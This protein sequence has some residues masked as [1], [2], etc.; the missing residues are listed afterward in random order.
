MPGIVVG[1][2]GSTHSHKALAWAAQEAAIRNAPLTVLTVH[3]AVV[4]YAGGPTTY[5]GDQ[6]ETA[7]AR[8]AALAETEKVLS[9]LSGGRPS[10]VTVTAV[11]GLPAQELVAASEGADLIVVGSRGSGGFARL[12]LGSVTAQV[13]EHAACPV[14]IVRG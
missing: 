5:P 13:A 4:G 8:D 12:L 1:V 7:Q 2:D 6:A 14:T 3:Q 11:H 10:D 9:E